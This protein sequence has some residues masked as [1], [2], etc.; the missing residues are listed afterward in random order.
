MSSAVVDQA[1]DLTQVKQERR[2]PET[3]NVG[4]MLRTAWELFANR[5][6]HSVSTR[7]IAAAAGVTVGTINYNFGG[8][9]GLYAEM[10]SRSM[11]QEQALVTG[12][13]NGVEWERAA[14]EAEVLCGVLT[15][16]VY[17]YVDLVAARPGRSR[18][19]LSRW[20][21]GPDEE[22]S[23]LEQRHSLERFLPIKN[24]LR[25]AGR[26]GIVRDDLDLGISLKAL[27]WLIHCYFVTGPTDWKSWHTD[28]LE[29]E[30]L[31]RFKTFMGEY[32]VRMLER[33]AETAAGGGEGDRRYGPPRPDE[34][35]GRGERRA[36]I[37]P[38]SG[39]ESKSVG[40]ILRAATE[41][42]AERG[43]EG[44]STREIAARAGLNVSTVNYHVGGK[45]D[46]YQ[47]INQL[48]LRQE[49]AVFEG[50]WARINPET[51]A[52]R[53]EV[54]EE[55]L[56]RLLETFIGLFVEH[57]E[58]SRLAIA[59]W[60]EDWDEE[61]VGIETDHA[62]SPLVPV[63][64]L[65]DRAR[66]EGVVRGDADFGILLKSVVWMVHCYCVTGPT[67]WRSWHTDPQDPD[68]LRRFE[69]FMSDYMR[70][71]LGLEGGG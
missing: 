31:A 33:G 46:L 6:Y 16:A 45:R 20:F 2:S 59:W 63:R 35:L 39:Y 15:R 49:R 61:L 34:T 29:P 66:A 50:V 9:R 13:I 62:F 32:V 19:T 65:L 30:N 56:W 57:P 26:E 55:L 47:K 23:P 67:D 25:H 37:G 5:S 8:K 22:L 12:I 4:R 40:R 36:G 69:A 58:R 18:L 24:L 52:R 71:M 43:Y 54:L 53:P 7:E 27:G 17:G 11:E 64:D 41:V 51:A 68:N 14:H 3:D 21:E 48:M 38:G 60:F 44:A 70:R 42:F 1:I 10:L 28:P